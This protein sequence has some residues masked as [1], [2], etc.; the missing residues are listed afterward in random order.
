MLSEKFLEQ[1]EKK[2]YWYLGTNRLLFTEAPVLNS[3]WHIIALKNKSF[4]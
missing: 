2:A 4:V 1:L 3:A